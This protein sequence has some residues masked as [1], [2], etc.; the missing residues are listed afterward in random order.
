MHPNEH[1]HRLTREADTPLN[2]IERA[3]I[4]GALRGLWLGRKGRTTTTLYVPGVRPE[5]LPALIDELGDARDFLDC[6]MRLD[7]GPRI[8]LEVR[9]W[10]PR[11]T[12][13]TSTARGAKWGI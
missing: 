9:E 1:T 7:T 3:S 12:E 13:P 8:V 11:T 6:R 10:A 4:K 5:D 2:G